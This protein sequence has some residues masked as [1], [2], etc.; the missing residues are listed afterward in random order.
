MQRATPSRRTLR[1]VAI[2]GLGLAAAFNVLAFRHAWSFTH[3]TAGAP[4]IDP[5]HLSM[6][7]RIRIALAGV[8][9]GRPRN[10]RTPRDAGLPYQTHIIPGD[11]ARPP[12][13]AW[14]VPGADTRPSWSSSM[15]TAA[16]SRSCSAMPGGSTPW[17][18]R[19]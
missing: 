15:V 12:L 19:C 14:L 3:T 10:T 13:E 4:R 8:P 5:R 18:P 16:P 17:G 7:E 6:G 2:G 9:L 11:G 1:R